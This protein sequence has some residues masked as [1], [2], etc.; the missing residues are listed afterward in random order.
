[1]ADEQ[2]YMGDTRY[3]EQ[4]AQFLREEKQLTYTAMHLQPGQHVLDVGCG[5]GVDTITL[6]AFI[7]ASGS[8][9][10]VDADSA[11]VAAAEHRASPAGVHDRVQHRVPDAPALPFAAN[12]FDAVR[13]ERLFQHLGDP[14]AALAELLRVPRP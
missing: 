14:R 6:A 7:G 1:M 4:A 9:D 3:L 12:A 13:G 11:M 2:G 5:P 8:V 10:G